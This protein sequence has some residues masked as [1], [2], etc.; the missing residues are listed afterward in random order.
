MGV[1]KKK[2]TYTMAE[3]EDHWAGYKT[4]KALRVLTGGK[5]TL[6]YPPKLNS[7]GGL[8]GTRAESVKLSQV[9]TFPTY[10]KK[11]AEV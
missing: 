7:A 9:C 5:W 1:D 4:K 8:E 3:L 10:L 6:I 11:Y 2:V